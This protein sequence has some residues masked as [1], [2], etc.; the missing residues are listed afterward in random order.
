M[1]LK[2]LAEEVLEWKIRNFPRA[3]L[4]QAALVVGEEAGEVQRAV[5]KSLDGIRGTSEEWVIQLGKEAAQLVIGL[6]A[7]TEMAGLDLESEIEREWAVVRQR[8]WAD[9]PLNGISK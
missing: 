1:D 7:L 8:N 3:D 6:S 9:Y 5:L 2:K 4:A